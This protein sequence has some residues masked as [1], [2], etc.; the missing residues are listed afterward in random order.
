MQIYA[1]KKITGISLFPTSLCF[2]EKMKMLQK[3]QVFVFPWKH[4]KIENFDTKVQITKI[5]ISYELS[6][7][8][9]GKLHLFSHFWWNM[10]SKFIRSRLFKGILINQNF[11]GNKM[12]EILKKTFCY[13]WTHSGNSSYLLLLPF[14]NNFKEQL[15][16]SK[17][18]LLFFQIWE[19]FATNSFFCF[20]RLMSCVQ[21]C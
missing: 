9:C 19:F 5:I 21:N 10:V 6:E 2:H 16:W 14:K 12:N 4:S 7:F 20:F 15:N 13:N 18:S 11:L 8:L 17:S 3:D 1:L